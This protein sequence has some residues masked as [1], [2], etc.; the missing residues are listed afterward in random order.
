MNTVGHKRFGGAAELLC[1]GRLPFR[2]L[3]VDGVQGKVSFYYTPL[4]I[5]IDAWVSGLED[6]VYSLCARSGGEERV[7]MPPL[8]SRGGYAWRSCLTGKLDYNVEGVRLR[9]DV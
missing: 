6:G 7:I 8:Y 4:G 5:L 2:V 3:D 9:I 1:R